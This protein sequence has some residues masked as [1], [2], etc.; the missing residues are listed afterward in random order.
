MTS[1]AEILRHRP[2][3]LFVD[4]F[5]VVEDGVIADI[6]PALWEACG[7]IGLNNSAIIMAE[8]SAQLFGCLCRLD[9]DGPKRPGYLLALQNINLAQNHLP[10]SLKVA[11]VSTDKFI[12]RYSA[13]AMAGSEVIDQFTGDLAM[14]EKTATETSEKATSVSSD[15][16]GPGP[17]WTAEMLSKSEALCEFA[18]R[19]NPGHLIFQ[20]HFP[21]EPIVPGIVLCDIICDLIKAGGFTGC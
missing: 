16:G 14:P 6:P 11:R 13:Q 7:D 2:P 3:F 20:G 9:A 8:M 5:A 21:E 4:K 17:F 10:T 15:C 12:H 18:V 1:G 19:F